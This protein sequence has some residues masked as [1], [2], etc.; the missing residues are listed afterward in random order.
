MRKNNFRSITLSIF[1]I[2]SIFSL[3]SIP[4]LNICCR[5]VQNVSVVVNWDR[6]SPLIRD[7]Q[8]G[9]RTFNDNFISPLEPLPEENI[10]RYE[11]LLGDTR[12]A[13]QLIENGKFGIIYLAGGAG[14]RLGLKPGQTKATHAK[15]GE[16]V[17][18]EVLCRDI[19]RNGGKI[20][21]FI[22]T[23]ANTDTTI[24]EHLEA[25]NYYGLDSNIFFRFMDESSGIRFVA[26][27]EDV[28]AALK[29][30]IGDKIT[31]EEY[32]AALEFAKQYGGK[33]LLELYREGVIADIRQAYC[34]T[35]NDVLASFI[36]NG[37]LKKAIEEGVEALMIRNDANFGATIDPKIIEAFLKSGNDVMVEVTPKKPGEVG[38]VAALVNGNPAIV[39]VPQIPSGVDQ[40]IF[41]DFNTNTIYIKVDAILKLFGFESREEFLDVAQN[42]ELL[43]QRV[44]NAVSKFP[45]IMVIRARNIEGQTIPV[46]EFQNILGPDLSKAELDI[47]FIRVPRKQRYLNVKKKEDL[48][49]LA[50]DVEE[51]V[52]SLK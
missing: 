5:R 7:Y 41:P 47:G 30:Q 34:G 33:T 1:V 45:N 3:F 2:F 37:G 25:N 32:E 50:P 39:E 12:Q 28:E 36:I 20:P 42:P 16:H 15:V 19:Q 35:G 4:S 6:F 26:R 22:S 24:A 18:I 23:S 38:G 44:W 10:L 29:P 48:T 21:V 51:V 40:D 27:P 49:K 43:R 17:P 13:Q 8:S 46:L 14:T 9:E 11:E 31:Q 52:S